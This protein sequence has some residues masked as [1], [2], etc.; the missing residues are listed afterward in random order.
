M[1]NTFLVS[2]FVLFNIFCAN[3]QNLGL[4][5]P[6]EKWSQINTDTV[7]LIFPY[8]I[9]DEAIRSANLIHNIAKY[10]TLNF[11]AKLRKVNIF[12]INQTTE[13]N[14]YIKYFPFHGKFFMMP[15]QRPFAGTIDWTDIL[16]IHEYRHVMQFNGGTRGF[17]A[18]VR[19][20]F[21]ETIWALMMVVGAPNWFYEGDA[22]MQETKM[23]FSGRGRFPEF[24]ARFN[25]IKDLKKPFGYEKMRCGSFRDYVP[26]H[27]VLGY[28]MI[29]YGDE[30]FGLG[31]WD[32]VFKNALS[33]SDIVYPFSRSLKKQT[34]FSTS[35][36]YKEMIKTRSEENLGLALK[37]QSEKKSISKSKNLIFYSY[38]K[39]VE[40]RI[41][42]LKSS[43][44]EPPAIVYL[45]SENLNDERRIISVSTDFGHYDVCEDF[46]V[47][48]ELNRDIRWK[49]VSYSNIYIYGVKS[50][51]IKKLTNKTR[52]FSP[53][54]SPD[55]S[56]IAVI[57]AD[58]SLNYSLVL[59]DK[60]TGAV[61]KKIENKVNYRLRETAWLD[62][63]NIIVIADKGNQ[64]LLIR[65]DLDSGSFI[66]ITTEII[67]TIS[68]V[69]VNENKV[70]FSSFLNSENGKQE[71]YYFDLIQNRY[72]RYQ[73]QLGY[74]DL[75]PETID[76]N[77]II[78]CRKEF[79]KTKLILVSGDDFF[80]QDNSLSDLSI[81][82]AK[83][84]L[85]ANP[86][87]IPV[88]IANS[89]TY[90]IKDFKPSFKLVNF[91]SWFPYTL[92]PKLFA[93]FYSEDYLERLKFTLSPFFNLNDSSFGISTNLDYGQFYPVFSLN[94][95]N[96]FNQKATIDEGS[97]T[98]DIRLS[99]LNLSGSVGLPL[100][101]NRINNTYTFHPKLILNLLSNYGSLEKN[102]NN[103]K[104]RLDFV[105]NFSQAQVQNRRSTLPM[106]GIDFNF[107]MNNILKM[108]DY[109]GFMSTL[110]F[111]LPGFINN[112]GVNFRL[113]VLSNSKKYTSVDFSDLN[114]NYYF[115]RSYNIITD[116]KRIAGLKINYTFP[117]MYPDKSL[118]KFIFFKRI[119]ANIF[120]DHDIFS[121]FSDSVLSVHRTVGLEIRFDNVY[122]RDFS[123]PVGIG[124][125]YKIDDKDKNFPLYLR[126]IIGF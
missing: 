10:D 40:N 96:T 69:S 26:N 95:S 106:K 41:Y 39:Y 104:T 111:Y 77:N 21:G 70:Y 42:A 116:V 121:T 72:F 109:V 110:N 114:T 84:D 7:R 124:L 119:R 52:F 78:F 54:I 71:I 101:I 30:R 8:A 53:S 117:L 85:I 47:W 51:K 105:L 11:D 55:R 107:R 15:P 122:F 108:T 91:H 58:R 23:S 57:E 86:N 31:V 80:T 93:D 45:D 103:I 60:T 29:K 125:D 88:D 76:S 27:Y 13:S 17:S 12:M 28:Q 115:A 9:S 79:N 68:D 25:S 16:S 74:G 97:E 87:F 18:L 43:F 63:H 34:G 67:N 35:G 94:L 61:E 112:H 66:P 99:T 5:P 6:S 36:L 20:V 123:I 19:E 46:I 33:Y 3:S 50:R 120:Y 62:P 24:Y 32:S 64:N 37:D 98:K 113:A 100:Q 59:L 22:V 118:G 14:G 102:A 89:R 90:E 2:A 73:N 49:G 44:D 38:P 1:K 56:T 82:N 92:P 4:Y 83:K 126:F 81:N 65:V 48:D 75:M